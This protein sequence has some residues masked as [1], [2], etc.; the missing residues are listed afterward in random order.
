MPFS[1]DAAILLTALLILLILNIVATQATRD[2]PW[3]GDT[4]KRRWLLILWILPVVGLLLLS[5]VVELG[6]THGERRHTDGG[7]EVDVGG[8]SEGSGD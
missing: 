1:E 7:T 8:G 6:V 3:L 5:H 4:E 2:C